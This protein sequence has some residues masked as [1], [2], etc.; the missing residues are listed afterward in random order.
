VYKNVHV[1]NAVVAVPGDRFGRGHVSATRID[2]ARVRELKPVRGV[3]DVK[4]VATSVMPAGGSA[5]KPPATIHQRRVVAT[6]PPR[7]FSPALQAQGLGAS[8][9]VTSPMAPRIVPAPKRERGRAT[10]ATTPATA[11]SSAE[12]ASRGH[13][14]NADRAAPPASRAIPEVAPGAGRRGRGAEGK[15]Q[16]ADDGARRPGEKT[17]PAAAPSPSRPDKNVERARPQVPQPSA[18]AVSGAVPEVA[19]GASRP[20]RG[21]EDKTQGTGRRGPRP[22]EDTS[23]ATAPPASR[24]ATD[25][26]RTSRRVQQ[27]PAPPALDPTTS[28]Q[29][30]KPGPRAKA[31]DDPRGGGEREQDQPSK[32][33]DE[34][35]DRPALRGIR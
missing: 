7:D 13:I 11:P 15:T 8:R 16:G 24:P 14:P 29:A 26:E 30:A 10:A 25:S 17:S 5:V 18:P 28:R 31:P 12:K 6:R 27:P 1:H 20:G 23:R 19:P 4:P 32:R 3:L 22:D 9:E 35:P 34:R 2:H 33:D 21:A